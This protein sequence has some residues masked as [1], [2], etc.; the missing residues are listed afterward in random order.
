MR[1]LRRIAV[2]L[3]AL[4]VFVVAVVFG[5]SEYLIRRTHAAPLKGILVPTDAASIAEGARIARIV[6]CR[7]CHKQD[8]RGGVLAESPA[9]GRVVGPALAPKV[10]TYSDAELERLIRRGIKRDGTALHIM[11]AFA[12][13]NLADEDV[14]RIIA[15]LRSLKPSPNDVNLPM[16]YGPMLR[17][18]LLGGMLPDSV[19]RAHVEAPA[20]RPAE[21]G[22]YYVK[23]ICMACHKL[24]EPNVMADTGDVAPALA[25]MGAAYQPAAFKRLLHAG[26]PMGS[27][28]LKMMAML[29]RES[30]TSLSDAEVAAIHAYLTAESAKA[31]AQ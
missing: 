17:V 20:R 22:G 27:T 6:A 12:H 31:P 5:G 15:W 30:F 16:Q 10:A 7:D 25:M 1:W 21:V 26:K 13:A 8:G 29:S 23:A 19:G 11:P 14:G 4:V 2:V 24:H 28:K 9:I 18:A 3:A